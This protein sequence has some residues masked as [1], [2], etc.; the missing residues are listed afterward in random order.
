MFFLALDKA[1]CTKLIPRARCEALTRV[2]YVC[3]YK[4]LAVKARDESKRERLV[5]LNNGVAHLRAPAPRPPLRRRRRRS[6]RP[7]AAPVA[8]TGFTGY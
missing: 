4:S 8:L 2:V 7:Q 3:V 5:I 1:H 6:S